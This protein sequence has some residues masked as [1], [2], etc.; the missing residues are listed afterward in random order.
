VPLNNTRC[1]KQKYHEQSQDETNQYFHNLF[2]SLP[3][4]LKILSVASHTGC[5]AHL[6]HHSKNPVQN[7][8][9]NHYTR[10]NLFLTPKYAEIL[11]AEISLPR[12]PNFCRKSLDFQ[13]RILQTVI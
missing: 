2:L 9:V 5:R 12:S 11:P 1:A 6:Q 8:Y 7:T 13:L 4:I 10:I 3:E